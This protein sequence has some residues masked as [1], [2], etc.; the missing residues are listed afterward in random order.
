MRIQHNI[1]ALN[2][3]R[4]FRG[5]SDLEKKNVEKLASG[6]RIN[7]AADDAAG[8][9]ISEQMRAQ[10]TGLDQAFDNAMDGVSLVETIEGAMEEVHSMLNRMSSLAVQSANGTYSQENRQSI[11]EEVDQ[12]V[13]EVERIK[14]TTNF[15]GLPLL[16]G[17]QGGGT[18]LL[19]VAETSLDSSQLRVELPNLNMDNLGILNISVETAEKARTSLEGLL[20]GIDYVSS[21][22]GKVGAYENRLKCT[23]NNLNAMESNIT[24]SESR[25]RDVNMAKE[26]MKRVKN[27]IFGESAQAMLAQANQTPEGLLPLL[28]Q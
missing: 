18:I 21:Q 17:D 11:Q 7:R 9:N 5:N 13:G 22:R 10:V 25:I 3:H 1:K 19:Q 6:Y 23:A 15:N 27:D 4:T 2:A 24:A 14:D 8:L 20:K 12:L 26:E 16:R 28:R